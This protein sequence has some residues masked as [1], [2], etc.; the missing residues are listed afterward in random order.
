[1]KATL[2][3]L[4]FSSVQ[5]LAQETKPRLF[6][7]IYESGNRGICGDYD[8]VKE[9]VADYAEFVIRRKQFYETNKKNSYAMFID[10]N[11]AIVIYRYE[12]KISG[13]N[14][15]SNVVSYKRAKTIEECQKLLSDQMA[16]NPKDFTT[17]PKTLFTWLGKP[18]KSEY[19]ADYGGLKG[20]FIATDLATKSII[21]AQLTNTTK[22]Q[23]A[24][25]QLTTDD[26]KK[27]FELLD[28]GS[29]LTKKFDTETLEVKVVY[30]KNDKPKEPFN[31]IDFVKG[32]IRDRVTKKGKVITGTV[33]GPR[34]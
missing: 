5:F 4:F 28:P 20:K 12:S 32:H 34:G 2:F 16:K 17:Q 8:F 22:D 30:K 11:E 23:L 13:W 24:Y 15:N 29:T 33:F 26:G 10:N 19:V 6:V 7:G 18:G 14:C 9:E 3:I 31:L 21:L 27:H 25:V 1:M